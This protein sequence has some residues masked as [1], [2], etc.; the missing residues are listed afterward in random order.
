MFLP[1]RISNAEF[2]R[3]FR[4]PVRVDFA[5]LA[6]YDH[7]PRVL[8]PAVVA[9]FGLVGFFVDHLEAVAELLLQVDAVRCDGK[10]FLSK[11]RVFVRFDS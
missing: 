9:A 7:Q 5:V 1:V 11:G 6:E 8:C 3:R 10:G 2:L 4:L